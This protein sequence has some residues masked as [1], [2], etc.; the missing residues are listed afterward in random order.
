VLLV[1][2]S[3]G[4]GKTSLALEVLSKMGQTHKLYASTRVSP[5][6]LRQH[7]PWIDEVIDNM[8]GRT[9]KGTWIDELHDL[10]RAEPDNIF[11]QVLR[12]KHSRRK[13]LLV[14]DSWEGA[15]RNSNEEGRRMMESAIFSEL[16]ESGVSVLIVNEGKIGGL[17]YLVDGIVT[18]GQFEVDERKLRLLE[19]NK[20]RGF[21]V[22]TPRILFSLDNAR[23]TQLPLLPVDG[24]RAGPKT[25]VPIP[26]S[27]NFFSTGCE[28]LDHVL[29]GGFQRGAFALLELKSHV[30]PLA[31]RSLL[32]I[33][34][35]NF[36]KQGGSAFIVPTGTYSSESSAESL[37][38]LVGD[39][40]L[41]QRVR[42]AEYNSVPEKKWRMMLKGDLP[43]DLTVFQKAWNSLAR[44]GSDMMLNVDLDKLVQVY[45]EDIALPGF[46]GIGEGLRDAGA[47]NLAVASRDTKVKE[48]FLR[49]ADYHLKIDVVEGFF[50]LCGVKPY[51]PLYGVRLGFE[52]GYPSLS[53]VEAV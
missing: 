42:I 52:K 29:G 45:G 48:E 33:V 51:T 12:L 22:S 27:K 2:G 41:E 50:L 26:H 30:A 16:D 40:A 34:R 36:V 15:L 3:P 20:L 23:F 25:F 21:R 8:T 43:G 19:V 6:K 32:N 18:L 4:S 13:A 44:F 47:L 39:E 17:D 37:R 5:Q 53:L 31:L 10:R 9:S 35:A 28:D 7:F 46:A 11:N 1:Q 24:E 14:I 38:P 49:T